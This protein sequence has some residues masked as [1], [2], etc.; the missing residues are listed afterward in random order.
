MIII[1]IQSISKDS[2]LISLRLVSSLTLCRIT[3]L[4]AGTQQQADREDRE[5]LGDE[6]DDGNLFCPRP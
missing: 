5:C 1:K 6:A 2:Q 4:D 3:I